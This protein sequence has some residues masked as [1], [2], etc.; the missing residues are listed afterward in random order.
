MDFST[1]RGKGEGQY[2]NPSSVQGSA[3]L[4]VKVLRYGILPL[5]KAGKVF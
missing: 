1:V 5:T 4:T 3:I 2:A